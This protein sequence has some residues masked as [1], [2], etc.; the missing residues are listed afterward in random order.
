M[1]MLRTFICTYWPIESQYFYD[2]TLILLILVILS[3]Y[4]ILKCMCVYNVHVESKTNLY[5]S[6]MSYKNYNKV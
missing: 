6:K 1:F 3:L 5:R 4:N 2:T